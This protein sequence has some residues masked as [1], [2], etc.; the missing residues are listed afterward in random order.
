MGI[1]QRCETTS[2][3]LV[4]RCCSGRSHVDDPVAM[5]KKVPTVI[6]V[7]FDPVTALVQ[8]RVVSAASQHKIR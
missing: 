5:I 1:V 7:S 3:A 6:I 2:R 8:Q 4:V